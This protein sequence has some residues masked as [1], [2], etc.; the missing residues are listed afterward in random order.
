MAS[1]SF[2]RSAIAAVLH[3]VNRPDLM[4]RALYEAILAGN[5]CLVRTILQVDGELI[6]AKYMKNYALLSGSEEMVKIMASRSWHTYDICL[7]YRPEA[8]PLTLDF[9][10]RH[11][12]SFTTRSCICNA[13][14]HNNMELI[15]EII[16]K[17]GVNCFLPAENYIYLFE[18]YEQKQVFDLL[19]ELHPVGSFEYDDLKSVAALEYIREKGWT[20]SHKLGTPIS[21][22]MPSNLIRLL[23]SELGGPNMWHDLL[24]AVIRDK[25]I[26]LF[27]ELLAD[28]VSSFFLYFFFFFFRF[29]P[30]IP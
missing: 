19:A 29:S 13:I 3:E 20:L 7:S 10:L 22:L 16:R 1:K 15:N 30:P 26:A 17:Q 23:P 14:Q 9:Y 6:P 28:R 21:S 12:P 27:K 25:N 5:T 11:L 2:V 24:Y 8:A 18:R 4:I